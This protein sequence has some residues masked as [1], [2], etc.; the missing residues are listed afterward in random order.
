M[1]RNRMV[2]RGATALGT[3][4]LAAAGF[5]AA[6][7]WQ[8]LPFQAS[9][10]SDMAAA[11]ASG[12]TTAEEAGHAAAMRT[13]ADRIVR[14]HT[15]AQHKFVH[16]EVTSQ[17]AERKHLRAAADKLEA[18]AKARERARERAARERAREARE[19]EAQAA[20]SRSTAREP[21]ASGDPPAI[22][23]QM[24]AA[25]GWSDSEFTCLDQLWEHESGWNPHASNPS[26]GAYGIPQALPGSKMASAG[27]DW[28]DNPRTQIEWGL[29]Y[30][31]DR[32]GTP[33]GAWS[34]FESYGSY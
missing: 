6:H 3:A 23:R 17:R 8:E 33:C 4:A 28:E 22:A 34:H 5:V 20:A 32:Y 29:G 30:I 7:T 27:S 26:T 15:E 19:Q 24:V 25:R 11:P 2:I 1:L 18:R 12:G 13:D 21:I 9:T 16:Q 14:L 31:S 10:A